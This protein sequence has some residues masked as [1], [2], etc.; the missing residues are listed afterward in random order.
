MIRLELDARD[1]L[2]LALLLLLVSHPRDSTPLQ[3]DVKQ[4]PRPDQRG[5]GRN[6]I[7]FA[8]NRG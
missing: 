4:A 5:E 3:R 6:T 1:L 7:P 8:A 2:L